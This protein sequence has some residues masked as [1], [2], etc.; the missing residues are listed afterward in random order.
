[1]EDYAAGG[2]SFEMAGLVW[3]LVGTLV[4]SLPGEFAFFSKWVLIVW[5]WVAC[6]IDAWIPAE[7][8]AVTFPVTNELALAIAG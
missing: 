8:A 1:M 2:L 6:S 7:L 3:L 4:G 5:A